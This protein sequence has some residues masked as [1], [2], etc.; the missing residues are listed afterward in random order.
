MTGLN[1]RRDSILEIG[2]V[3]VEHKKVQAKYQAM[4]CPH[5]ELAEEVV[6]LTGITN[7]MARQGRELDEVFPEI[8]EF[9]G[10]LVLLGHNVIFDYGFLKQ[11]AMNRNVAFERKGLDTLKLARKLLPPEEKRRCSCYVIVFIS[12]GRAVTGRWTTQWLQG[13][14]M[15]LSRRRMKKSSQSYLLRRRLCFEQKSS[16]RRQAG[17]KTICSS[18]RII[19]I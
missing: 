16:P 9:C 3:R 13:S 5:L 6:Q 11:A 8:M 1:A 14:C 19:I 17:R 12:S 4:I 15:R 7:E 2:A 10:D 18:W